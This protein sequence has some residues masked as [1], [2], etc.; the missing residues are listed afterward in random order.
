M[1]TTDGLAVAQRRRR[2]RGERRG[3]RRRSRRDS[4]TTRSSMR[5]R[6]RVELRL[7]DSTERTSDRCACAGSGRGS[8]CRAGTDPRPTPIRRTSAPR[9][10]C[11]NGAIVRRLDETTPRRCGQESRP[12]RLCRSTTAAPVGR[13]RTAAG[14][15]RRAWSATNWPIWSIVRD[16]AQV[17]LALRVAPG[18]QAVAAEHDAVA[19][20]RVRR[21]RAEASAPARSRD[22][23]T[24]PR[25]CAGRSAR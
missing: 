3:S 18:E 8:S 19:A 7:P 14:L 22:A 12:R 9:R 25:R 23:A 20:G 4:A 13:R 15:D 2:R 1:T 21:R 10:S 11:P 24:A 5:R 16:A 17:A 6:K